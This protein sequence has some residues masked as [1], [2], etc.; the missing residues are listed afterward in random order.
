MKRTAIQEM[1]RKPKPE[2]EKLLVE[3]RDR[4]WTL[5]NDLENG[6]VKNVREV[7]EIK[8]NIARVETFLKLSVTA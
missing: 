4:L 2:L 5:K 8:K 7:R 3:F 1:K 6:K